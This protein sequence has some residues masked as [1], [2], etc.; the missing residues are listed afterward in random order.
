MQWHVYG[1]WTRTRRSSDCL[2][3]NIPSHHTYWVKSIVG[4]EHWFK[5]IYS[6]SDFS[7]SSIGFRA[8]RLFF[9]HRLDPRWDKYKTDP[10]W[11][12][13]AHNSEHLCYKFILSRTLWYVKSQ[14]QYLLLTIC[15]KY[16]LISYFTNVDKFG[17]RYAQFSNWRTNR[18]LIH[19]NQMENEMSCFCHVTVHCGTLT[20]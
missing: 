18:P 19:D 16:I 12:W 17:I 10:T 14:N 9:S 5:G 20:K 3:M 6:R 7:L 1:D 11:G 4:D 8:M 2:I 15:K 13:S